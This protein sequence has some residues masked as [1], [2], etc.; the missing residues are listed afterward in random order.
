[1]VVFMFCDVL[2]ISDIFGVGENKELI[3]KHYE[4]LSLQY[5]VIFKVVKNENFQ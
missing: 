2:S 3:R 1:M 4:N 5:P